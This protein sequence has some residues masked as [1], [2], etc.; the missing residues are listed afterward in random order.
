[1]YFVGDKKRPTKMQRKPVKK[2]NLKDNIKDGVTIMPI[3]YEE[4]PEIAND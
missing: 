1:M 3:I 4:P 2:E